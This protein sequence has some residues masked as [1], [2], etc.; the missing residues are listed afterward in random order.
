MIMLASAV[1]VC[2][3]RCGLGLADVVDVL[4][5]GIGLADVVDVLDCGI[6]WVV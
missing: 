6:A 4:D 1:S 2:V 3:G 5:C